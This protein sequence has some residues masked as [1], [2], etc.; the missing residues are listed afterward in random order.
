MADFDIAL[1]A[2]LAYEGGY[3]NNPA[4]AGGETVCG[5][6]RHF[7][8]NW[9]G[10]ALVDHHKMLTSNLVTLNTAILADSQL[11]DAVALFYRQKYWNFD[12]ITSQLIANKMLDMEVNFG[13]GT[14]VRIIQQGLNHLGHSVT[15]DGNLGPATLALVTNAKEPDLLHAM[16]AYSAL[17]RVNRVQA[18]PEQM[19]FIEGWLWRDTA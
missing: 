10:W 16:R 12:K 2:L 5:I 14:A 7:N 15:L 17:Y 8:P 6:S 9:L 1:T 18:H 19:E 4:D 11:T 3:S 13:Q